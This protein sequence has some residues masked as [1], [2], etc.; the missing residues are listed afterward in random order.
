MKS[1]YNSFR[2]VWVAALSSSL[3]LLPMTVSAHGDGDGHEDRPAKR[4]LMERFDFNRDGRLDEQ[5]RQALRAAKKRMD[6]N[7]DGQVSERERELAHRAAERLD[8]NG[9]P[10]APHTQ[11]AKAKRNASEIATP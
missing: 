10:S 2:L 5:E 1:T 7:N 3:C 4:Q 11:T 9:T 6:A 8:K